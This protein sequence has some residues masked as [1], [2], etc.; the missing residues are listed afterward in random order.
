MEKERNL[1]CC[2]SLPPRVSPLLATTPPIALGYTVE[3]MFAFFIHIK[4]LIW[5]HNNLIPIFFICQ[6]IVKFIIKA[7]YFDA[8]LTAYYVKQ[9][10]SFEYKYIIIIIGFRLTQKERDR[11]FSYIQNQAQFILYDSV[12]EK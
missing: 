11:V 6:F 10:D 3:H 7:I 4:E 5:S 2:H 1:C 9:F 12:I 8:S